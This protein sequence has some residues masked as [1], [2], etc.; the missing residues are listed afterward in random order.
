MIMKK[1]ELTSD[2]L[3]EIRSKLK[4][5]RLQ[6]GDAL[7]VTPDTIGRWERGEFAIN[8]AALK[9]LDGIMQDGRDG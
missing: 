5:S 6:L 3:K 7:G 8:K 1:R 2:D 4:M 9:L